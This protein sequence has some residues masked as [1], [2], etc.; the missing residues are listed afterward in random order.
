MKVI[1]NTGPIIGL[2]KIG[3]IVLLRSMFGEVLIP[4]LVHKELYGKIGWESEQIDQALNDFIHVE[5]LRPLRPEVEEAIAHLDEGEKQ[6]IGLATT[7]EG[8]ALLLLDDRA[9][10]GA[11]QKLNIP[12]T[13]LIGILLLGK[14]RGLV[15]SVG[16]LIAELRKNRY[17][18][19]E[20]AMDVAKRLAGE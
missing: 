5:D 14:E 6:A 4:P 16:Y 18:L 19:S 12:V 3:R 2:A 1:S 20:E 10:R 9:G 13:G 11:A 7:V 17:W 15:E 8:N